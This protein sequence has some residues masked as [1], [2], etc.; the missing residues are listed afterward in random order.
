MDNVIIQNKLKKI[1]SESE[2]VFTDIANNYT[3]LISE[4][5]RSLDGL[6]TIFNKL[7]AHDDLSSSIYDVMSIMKNETVEFNTLHE[8][9]EKIFADF[10]KSISKILNLK[11][12]LDRIQENSEELD[13]ISLN[14]MVIAIKAGKDGGAFSIIADWLRKLSEQ[15]IATTSKLNLHGA[16]IQSTFR[17]FKKVVTDVKQS[18]NTVLQNFETT[19][20]D[21]LHRLAANSREVQAFLSGVISSITE[22]KEPLLCIINNLQYQDIIR[23]SVDHILL[24]LDSLATQ[25]G[26]KMNHLYFAIQ[27]FQIS[28]AIIEDVATQ[29][30]ENATEFSEETLKEEDCIKNINQ[31]YKKYLKV[32]VNKEEKSGFASIFLDF[33]ST[34]DQLENNVKDSIKVK[35]NLGNNSHTI[36]DSI[37]KMQKDLKNISDMSEEF[38]NVIIASKIEV[39]KYSALDKI[40]ASVSDMEKIISHIKEDIDEATEMI[41]IFTEEEHQL[42]SEYSRVFN[43]ENMTI[44]AFTIDIENSFRNLSDM[45][46]EIEL[47]LKRFNIFTQHFSESFTITR[48]AVNGLNSMVE[49]LEHISRE[50]ALQKESAERQFASLQNENS[51]WIFRDDHLKE[52]LDKFTIFAHKEYANMNIRKN[53]NDMQRGGIVLF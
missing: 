36:V 41:R 42:Q 10:E 11:T 1:I 47:M 12:L 19:L 14:S 2:Y 16:Q 51:N 35:E 43:K 6:K 50:I 34:F 31:E 8:Q 44:S 17:N 28:M 33:L 18:E 22:I 21:A 53:N 5:D 30:R 39:T 13:F 29:L 38:N 7:S 46:I 32:H 45:Y 25:K 4:L 40:K 52:L 27:I 37:L 26:D 23:Q 9:D 48:E 24:S 49:E 15:T 3:N 20:D